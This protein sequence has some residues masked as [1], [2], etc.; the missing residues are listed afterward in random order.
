[1][2]DTPHDDGSGAD[3][4]FRDLRDRP[5]PELDSRGLWRRIE[6]DLT[7]RSRSLWSRVFGAVGEQAAFPRFAYAAA[8]VATIA[9]VAWIGYSSVNLGAGEAQLVLL[10]P[11]G[12]AAGDPDRDAVTPGTPLRLDVRL[13]RG[14][15]GAVPEDVA[16]AAAL[17]VGGAD[18]LADA[19]QQIRALVPFEGL[20]IVGA[21]EGS[22][23]PGSPLAVELSSAY[24]L[25]ASAAT[26]S[27]EPTAI[28][29]LS[30][31]ELIGFGEQLVASDL[32]LQPGRLYILGVF[33]PAA[34][35]PSLIL[36]V[37]AEWANGEP[38][39]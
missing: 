12:D 38:Q 8:A 18:S 21:W 17:G 24:E 28:V 10:A 33:P 35:A 36:L 31:V 37:R 27:V 15:D 25:R 20:G 26:A 1:M 4:R 32:N 29:Q 7:P 9:A 11:A 23:E 3:S 5:T 39:R 30:D 2:S 22:L 19:R 6:A 13:V 16:A 14:Y 34:D